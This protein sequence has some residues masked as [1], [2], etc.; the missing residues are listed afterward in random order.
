MRGSGSQGPKGLR[1][2]VGPTTHRWDGIASRTFSTRWAAKWSFTLMPRRAVGEIIN[3]CHEREVLVSTGGFLEQVLFQ[4]KDAVKS[5]LR[6][7]K[8]RG[9]DTIEISSGFITLPAGDWLRLVEQV[10]KA[11]LREAGLRAK[12]EVGIQ[13]GQGG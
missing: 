7:C 2:S 12:P 10:Q 8:E 3:L 4:R 9:F 13:F 5:Y 1:R 11:G 6:E